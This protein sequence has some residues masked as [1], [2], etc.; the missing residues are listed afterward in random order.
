MHRD[1]RQVESD[2]FAAARERMVRDQLTARGIRDPAT[3]AAMGLVPREAFVP[4]DAAC[5]R[6]RRQGPAHRPWPDHLAAVHGRAHDRVV[7]P[8]ERGWPWGEDRPAVLDVGTGSGY[9]AA[10]LAQLGARVIFDR[11]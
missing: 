9:Q 2:T 11:A 7:G 8:P 3:L 10:V 6:L 4:P 5:L 1:S